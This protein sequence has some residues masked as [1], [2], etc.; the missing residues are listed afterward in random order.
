MRWRLVIGGGGFFFACT[1]VFIHQL[2]SGEHL[3]FHGIKLG[4]TASTVVLTILLAF[5]IATMIVFVL[6]AISRIADPKVLE[7]A[8][9]SIIAPQGFFQ[10]KNLRIAYADISRLVECRVYGVTSLYVYAGGRSHTILAHLLLNKSSY[11]EVKQFLS[12]MS[13]TPVS[14][15][16]FN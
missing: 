16:P 3:D 4:P 12:G 1:V 2:K 7:L 8:E 15:H 9:D 5:S 11:E 10:R 14:E 6:G 13:R